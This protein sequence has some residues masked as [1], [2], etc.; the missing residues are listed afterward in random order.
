M[1][2][3][4]AIGIFFLQVTDYLIRKDPLLILT[5]KKKALDCYL[6]LNSDYLE[7]LTFKSYVCVIHTHILTMT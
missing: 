5:E 2:F 7:I 6:R 3:F 4:L 1:H